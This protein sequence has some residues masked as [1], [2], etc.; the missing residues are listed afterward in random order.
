MQDLCTAE[1][2]FLD[3][4]FKSCPAPFAQLYSIHIYSSTLNGTVP[5]LYSLLPN[6]TKS[7]YVSLFNELRSATVKN[8]L[9]LNPKYIT[10]DYEQGAISAIKRVFPNSTIKGCNFHYNQ[11][12]FRKLQEL[13]LQ[14]GYYDSSSNDETS[15]KCLLQ[16]TGALAFM[17]IDKINTLWCDIMEKFDHISRSQE[18]FDYVTETWIDDGCL[19]PRN[20][21]NYYNFYG[22]RTNNGLEG[23]HHR[24]N[25]NIRTSTPNLYGVIEELKKDH[26]FNITTIKQV[27][28]SMKKPPRNKK[29]VFRNEKILTLMKSYQEGTLSLTVYFNKI[30][31]TIGK[32][33]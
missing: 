14:K 20:I 5:I 12:L 31:K 33:L 21:W 30:S 22:P 17:P 16:A 8:D 2:L 9:I 27:E 10:T 28:W 1:H 3:G 26:A 18:F 24:L 7:C 25:S 23:W 15:V 13:G 19:F 11:C 6:K 29:F 4:T 32:S